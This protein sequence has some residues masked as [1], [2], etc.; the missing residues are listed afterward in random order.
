L[1]GD[2]S[3]LAPLLGAVGGL[4]IGLNVGKWGVDHW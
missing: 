4:M 3:G 1:F 2:I